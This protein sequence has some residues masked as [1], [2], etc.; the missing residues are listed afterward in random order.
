MT[1][2]LFYLFAGLTLLAGVG[3][4][5][6]R[7]PVNGALFMILAFVGTAALF[8]LLEA[9]FLAAVQVLVYA[10]A[11]VVLF[12]F[13]LMLL[14]AEQAG[15]LRPSTPTLVASLI[16]LGL[17][18]AGVLALFTV[19]GGLPVAEPGEATATTIAA[20]GRLLFTKY[21]LPFQ[22]AGF[23]LLVAMLGVIHISR[24]VPDDTVPS[25]PSAP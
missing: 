11:V 10:G 17:L 23:L 12:L 16:G 4:V 1:D 2:F 24:R 20:F 8:V 9:F 25:G 14:D 7:N 5:A 19:E 15:R 13:I 18:A 21:M 22:L 3:M 6:S